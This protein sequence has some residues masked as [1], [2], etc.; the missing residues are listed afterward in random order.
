[1]K[2][3]AT[4]DHLA[5]NPMEGYQPMTDLF[6]DE[7]ILN[8]ESEE[9]HTNWRMYFDWAVNLHGRGIGTILIS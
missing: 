4:T 2:G 5:E 7:S 3:Q 8:I 9:E 6:P 1:M